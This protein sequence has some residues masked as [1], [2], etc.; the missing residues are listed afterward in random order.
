MH[1]STVSRKTLLGL[2]HE[3]RCDAVLCADALDDVLEQRSAVGH[4]S[5]LAK[6]ESG[7]EDAWSGL[8]KDDGAETEAGF[9]DGQELFL[10]DELS[11]KDAVDVDACEFDHV[12]IL[13]DLGEIVDGDGL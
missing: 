7:F 9:C 10:G 2:G 6:L 4:L 8:A 13:E 5:N 1:V 3:A 11:A 12:V